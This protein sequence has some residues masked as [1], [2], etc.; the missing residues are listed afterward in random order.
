MAWLDVDLTSITKD[1][2]QRVIDA[3][4]AIIPDSW[5]SDEKIQSTLQNVIDAY[6]KDECAAMRNAGTLLNGLGL[7]QAG[8]TFTIAGNVCSVYSFFTDSADDAATGSVI[9]RITN[10]SLLMTGSEV[11]IPAS[12]TLDA[13]SG[14]YPFGSS[15]SA[16][17]R[18][19]ERISAACTLVPPTDITFQ[20]GQKI[21]LKPGFHAKAGSHFRAFV[22]P[23]P[24]E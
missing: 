16:A 14:G 24:R 22:G 19:T 6:D 12:V 9:A 7:Y 2:K 13:S 4:K 3:A 15:R 5:V 18:A 23:E 8:T 11:D 10:D 1:V 20:A 17:F 21:T